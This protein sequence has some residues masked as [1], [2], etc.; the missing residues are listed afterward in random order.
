MTRKLLTLFTALALLLCLAPAALALEENS[1]EGVWEYDEYYCWFEFCEN[2]R[3]AQYGQDGLML[4]GVYEA[5]GDTLQTYLYSGEEFYSFTLDGATLTD[6]EGDTL[7]QSSLPDFDASASGEITGVWYNCVEGPEEDGT[8]C[9]LYLALYPAGYWAMYVDDEYYYYGPYTADPEAGTADLYEYGLGEDPLITLEID[10]DLAFNDEWDYFIRADLPF[11]GAEDSALSCA[12][13]AVGETAG[14]LGGV[15]K[16]DDSD[17]WLTIDTDAGT[18][19]V[20]LEDDDEPLTGLITAAGGQANLHSDRG[21]DALV[22]LSE[23]G[24]ALTDRGGDTL[25]RSELP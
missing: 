18:W 17:L 14:D 8:V 7:F 15:W 12:L 21:T 23:D 11:D 10:G 22:I 5:D 24:T 13:T 16:Y 6:D 20:A 19:T 3:F 2:G 4:D 25:S 1:F 9:D